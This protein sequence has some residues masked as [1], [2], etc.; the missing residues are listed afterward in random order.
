MGYDMN[1]DFNGHL[2]FNGA[3]FS[4]KPNGG[5]LSQGDPQIT[6]AFNTTMV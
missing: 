3:I 4:D 1:G 5:F 2:I 6:M